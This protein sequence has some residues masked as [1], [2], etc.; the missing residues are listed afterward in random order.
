[1][2]PGRK[3]GVRHLFNEIGRYEF[4]TFDLENKRVAKRTEFN[5]RPRMSLKTSSNGEVLYIYNAGT[6][7]DLYNAS[8]YQFMKTITLDGDG[9]SEL[10]VL[11]AAAAPMRAVHS[12][13]TVTWKRA[14]SFVTPYWRRLA[15]VLAISLFST[16]LALWLPLLSRDFFDTAL[17]GRDARPA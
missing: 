4:W 13:W 10:F 6:T 16:G 2:A 8:T 1:M 14:L 15:L 9:T 3:T 5:G 17:L 11:P 12:Q 7:I